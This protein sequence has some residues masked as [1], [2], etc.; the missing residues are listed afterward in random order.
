MRHFYLQIIYI[1]HILFASVLL[2]VGISGLYD[3]KINKVW[4]SI[5]SLLGFAAL[6]YH[7]YWLIDSLLRIHKD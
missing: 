6:G 5:L 3:R 2:Y 7:G 1:I 4:Y